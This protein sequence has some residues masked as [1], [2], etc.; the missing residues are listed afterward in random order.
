MKPPS[1]APTAASERYEVLDVLRGAALFGIISA[2]MI[3]HSLYLYL[4]PEAMAAIPTHGSDRVLDFL[5]L[6]LIE[7]K[8]YTIFSVLF[9]VGFSILLVRSRA[10]EIR[11]HRFF[12]R[13]VSLLFL[14]GLAHAVLLFHDDILQAYALCG[15]L[16]LPF[17]AARTRTILICAGLALLSVIPIKM[18]GGIPVGALKEVQ[19]AL[20]TRF[21][22]SH[23]TAVSA[24]TTGSYGD[25]VRLNL[26]KVFS[27]A[28]FLISSGMM[29]K[30]F[31]CFLLGFCLGRSGMHQRLADYRP[32]LRKVAL[33]GLAIGLPLN[34]VYAATFD[35]GS[36]WE[37]L[38]GTFGV[39]PLSAGYA[40]VLCL[41][42]LGP[43]GR[44][45][46]QYFA[47]IGRM[48]LTNYIG[49]SVICVFIYRSVGLGLGGTMGHT[50]FLPIGVA[51][52]CVQ[53]FM[54][55]LWL[56]R[57]RFGPI[58]WVWRV[59]TYGKWDTLAKRA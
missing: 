12:L 17:V 34:A 8:F 56:A 59:L 13:R 43:V 23:E 15:A 58:E 11:F 37:T 5:E 39:L 3:L 36:W 40:S 25:I 54:S 46:L 44:R 6:M 10:K 32:I 51:V 42:W 53:V 52:Y 35:S 21:G 48:A 24:W 55:R 20:L 18:L 31:G 27:Q 4:S 28:M 2:N 1:L 26:A 22:L 14:I 30:I 7:S 29:F 9:G 50:L 33:G 49:Q 19:N 45:R 47:P 16:L 38:A 41:L 57:F